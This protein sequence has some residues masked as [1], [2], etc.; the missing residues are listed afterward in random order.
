MNFNNS[1]QVLNT[2]LNGINAGDL[3]GVLALYS[4]DAMLI[5]T[6]FNQFLNTPEAIQGYFEKL[7]N[8]KR[9]SIDLHEKTVVTQQ[10]TENLHSIAG[11]Y[12]WRF[13]VNGSL[14]SFEARFTFV[15]DLNSKTPIIHHHSSQ[16]PRML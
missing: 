16:V 4:Q 15:C 14:M 2:W 1:N 6:F 9:L 3:D 8:H 12:C 7:G 5:P 10:M 11:V 13:E